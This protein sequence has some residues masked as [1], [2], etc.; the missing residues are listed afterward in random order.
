MVKTS[1]ST[2]KREV[3]PVAYD[4][5]KIIELYKLKA[6]AFS[7]ELAPNQKDYYQK[8]A[9]WLEE[10]RFDSP[11]EAIGA[12]RNT[13]YYEGAGTAKLA[14]D[15]LLR[16]KAAEEAG[17]DDVAE[18][19][20]ERK[21]KLEKGGNSYAFSQEWIDDFNRAAEKSAKY[22]E[23]KEL[24]GRILSGYIEIT[25]NPQSDHRRSAEKEINEALRELNSRGLTFDQLISQRAYMKLTM[26]TD[27]GIS[28]FAEFVR[29]FSE[30]RYT[31]DEDIS[32]LR[33]EQERLACWAAGNKAGI[34]AAGKTEKW[35]DA[36]CLAV[37]SDNPGPYDFI[38]LKEVKD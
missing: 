35:A 29:S 27:K 34:E 26:M 20:R 32:E 16:I 28:N 8:A 1:N 15:T 23:R 36:C 6:S 21:I 33:E 7:E 31:S 14:D 18:I 30:G 13:E 3:I 9:K 11:E 4:H 25:G 38:G 22:A 10:N 5:S 2:R 17:Y 19:H 12:M 24:F 37:P